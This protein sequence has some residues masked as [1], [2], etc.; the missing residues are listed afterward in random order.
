MIV[1]H[2]KTNGGHKSHRM[3]TRAYS[4]GTDGV[5][6]QPI[7]LS[8][9]HGEESKIESQLK[10]RSRIRFGERRRDSRRRRISSDTERRGSGRPHITLYTAGQGGTLSL[11]SPT[12]HLEP[13]SSSMLSLLLILDE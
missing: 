10:G 5:D 1:A 11:L 7:V 6:S 12:R 3:W 4:K 8:I 9:T 2:K 13:S